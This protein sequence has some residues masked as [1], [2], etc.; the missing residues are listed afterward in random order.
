MTLFVRFYDFQPS[1]AAVISSES[2][3][4]IVSPRE[5]IT[6][7]FTVTAKAKGDS[8]EAIEYTLRIYMEIKHF[9]LDLV[10]FRFFVAGKVEPLLDILINC[11]TISPIGAIELDKNLIELGECKVRLKAT[12][13][14]K[15]INSS[16]V[17]IPYTITK[18]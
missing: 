6:I 16:L 13:T 3:I 18:V 7:P 8:T 1:D 17:P 12:G 11:H 10:W 2:L 4:G 9:H 15:I 14:F 5:S